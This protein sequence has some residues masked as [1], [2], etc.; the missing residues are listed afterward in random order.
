MTRYPTSIEVERRIALVQAVPDLHAAVSAAA[1]SEQRLETPAAAD[2]VGSGVEPDQQQSEAASASGV[3]PPAA[4]RRL[5]PWLMTAAAA[6]LLMAGGFYGW[7]YWTVGRFQTSTDDA[8]VEADNTT[9][10]P[11]VS[12]YLSEVLVGDNQHVAAGQILARIDPRDFEIARDQA[13]ADVAAANAAIASKRA[14]LDIQGSTIEAA[15]AALAVDQANE[16]FARQEDKRY[17]DLAASGYGSLQNAQQAESRIAAASASVRRDTAALASAVKQ[18]DLLKAEIAQAEATLAHDRAIQRQAELNLSYATVR[19]PVDGVVGNRTLRVGQYVQAGTQLMAVVPT[20]D[21][22]IVANFKETQLTHVARGQPVDIEVDTFP[23]QVAHGH[24]DSIAPASG[25]QFALLP[26][27]NA[28]GNFTKIVQRIPV[29][30]S[31]DARGTLIGELRP[32]MSVTPT[33]DTRA[34]RMRVAAEQ[35]RI[36]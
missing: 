4:A 29:R 2:G 10:A 30:I 36:D 1:D 9:I 20:A 12:G 19:S 28:T 14:Q 7:Q 31:I 18:V 23:G 26:P 22:Y 16:K 15:Q 13:S 34:A 11:R 33:I 17:S 8:Y 3:P 25:Q 6:A 21:T 24:V 35:Q 27:D 32:G 5:R